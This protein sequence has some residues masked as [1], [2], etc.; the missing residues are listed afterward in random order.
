[1]LVQANAKLADALG[2]DWGQLMGTA[3]GGG[4]RPMEEGGS[5]AGGRWTGPEII[6]RIGISRQD[7]PKLRIYDSWSLFCNRRII[8]MGIEIQILLSTL[9]WIR[10][11][12]R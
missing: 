11:L 6:R 2:A 9:M 12:C 3:G 1:M 5:E 7:K 8:L 4:R 10:I